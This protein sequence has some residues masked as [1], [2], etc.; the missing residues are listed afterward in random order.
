VYCICI[1]RYTLLL[2]DYSF[3]EIIYLFIYFIYFNSK[4]RRK[5]NKNNNKSV[6]LTSE[7]QTNN[8]KTSLEFV[9]T[10]TDFE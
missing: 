8:N 1:I 3:F 9:L 6:K 7:I 5:N 10:V 4:I 2:K